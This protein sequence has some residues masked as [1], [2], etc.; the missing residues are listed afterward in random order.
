MLKVPEG[1]TRLDTVF[2]NVE[3]MPK[4]DDLPEEFKRFPGHTPWNQAVSTWF[5]KGAKFCEFAGKGEDRQPTGIEIGGVKFKPKEGV[6]GTQALAAIVSVLKSFEPKHE[7][8]EAACA[9]M[10]SQWF[11]IVPKEDV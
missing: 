10:L 8:K 7:H 3:H 6:N 5:F 4:Y 1:L 2:G 11:D 9:Y